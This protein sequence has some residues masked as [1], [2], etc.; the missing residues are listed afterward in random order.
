MCLQ[1]K[2]DEMKLHESRDVLKNYNECIDKYVKF[3][4]F[5]PTKQAFK[6][7]CGDWKSF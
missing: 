1:A 7:F 6:I 2:R 3:S 4:I 5:Y